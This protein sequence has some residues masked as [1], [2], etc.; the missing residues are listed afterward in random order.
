MDRWKIVVRLALFAGL[1]SAGLAGA[2]EAASDRGERERL[3]EVLLQRAEQSSGRELDPGFRAAARGALVRLPLAELKAREERDPAAGLGPLGAAPVDLAYRA[4]APCRI[5]DTRVAGGAMA[6]GVA[7]DFKVSGTGLQ[8]QG[9]EA[10]G[11]GVP[12]GAAT[13]AMINFVAVNATG[14]GNLRAW[15]FAQPP[16]P[17]P[18]ASI[19]NY[20]TV[21]GLNIANGIAV[22]LCDWSTG[23]CTAEIRVQTDV[24]GTHLVADIVGY[25]VP[26][27]K[28]IL[29]VGPL[30]SGDV[31]VPSTACTN[32]PSSSVTVDVPAA[33]QVEVEAF[34]AVRLSHTSGTI[35]LMNLQ[36]APANNDCSH[37]DGYGQVWVQSAQPTGN[38]V[39]TVPVSRVFLV[40]SP[41]S[42]TFYLNADMES[43]GDALDVILGGQFET[44]PTRAT[45]YP[46]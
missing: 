8:S 24:S 29:E 21:A 28:P 1:G 39:F 41:G 43:G 5:I 46:N 18:S 31:S 23:T 7:R 26:A 32:I 22:P 34:V 42:Y 14:G 19:L 9:G 11:C 33:G 10:A 20:A 16:V 30:P 15:A 27:H 13:A 25:F 12:L 36:F 2:Q 3:A 38:Y 6:P 40:G 44:M 45:Y 17:P 35:D 4:V 37:L